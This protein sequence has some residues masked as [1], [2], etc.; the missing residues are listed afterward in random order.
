MGLGRKAKTE[1]AGAKNGGGYW[2]PREDVKRVSNKL[3]RR[4]SKNAAAFDAL[5][6]ACGY[7]VEVEGDA[8]P[9]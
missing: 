8:E 1:H 2:G 4:A 9:S 6:E 7:E 3:R 5:L